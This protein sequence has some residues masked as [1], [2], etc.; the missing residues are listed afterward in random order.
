[1]SRLREKPTVTF[2]NEKLD[3]VIFRYFVS[4]FGSRTTNLQNVRLFRSVSQLI[5]LLEFVRNRIF[6]LVLSERVSPLAVSFRMLREIRL[7]RP[8]IL[9]GKI[10]R[11]ELDN[12]SID[13]VQ[14]PF[15]R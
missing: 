10:L 14:K 6:V 11:G 3:E 4:I 1:M 15:C 2:R 7:K 13:K 5:Q 12:Q 9:A 8:E